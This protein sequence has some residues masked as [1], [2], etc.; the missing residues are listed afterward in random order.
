MYFFETFINHTDW[1]HAH[2]YQNDLGGE[3]EEVTVFLKLKTQHMQI[4]HREII[5]QQR[6]IW[7][8]RCNEW[9]DTFL[10]ECL[11]MLGAN[12]SN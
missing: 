4:L 7:T 5:Q 9:A 2:V 10:N 11:W 1:K 12:L 8:M 3:A 6:S